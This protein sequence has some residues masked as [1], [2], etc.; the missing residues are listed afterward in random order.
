MTNQ[1]DQQLIK[2]FITLCDGVDSF[3]AQ[4]ESLCKDRGLAHHRANE[5]EP[6][7]LLGR[8][9]ILPRLRHRELSSESS[10]SHK[11]A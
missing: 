3:S 11:R 1:P 4:A 7:R 8:E 6:E 5:G 9:S 2:V 10:H